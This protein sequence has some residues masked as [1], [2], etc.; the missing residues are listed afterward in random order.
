MYF[1]S[2]LNWRT[3]FG[4]VDGITLYKGVKIKR[5]MREERARAEQQAARNDIETEKY[6]NIVGSIFW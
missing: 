4:H 5:C 3:Y 6:M 1:G 2:S